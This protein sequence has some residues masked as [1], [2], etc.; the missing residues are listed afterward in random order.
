[1]LD[2]V[3]NFLRINWQSKHVTIGL[4]E[5]LKTNGQTLKKKIQNLLNFFGL[6]KKV[7]TYVKDKGKNLNTMIIVLKFAIGCDVLRLEEKIQR[8]FFNH[9]FFKVCQ[10]ASNG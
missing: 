8:T 5:I 10:N 2:L 3:V 9:A 1:M 4:F 6:R 7:L